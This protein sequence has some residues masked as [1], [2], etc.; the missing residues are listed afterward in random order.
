MDPNGVHI[1]GDV[2]YLAFVSLLTSNNLLDESVELIRHVLEVLPN[3]WRDFDAQ[4]RPS[5]DHT[6]RELETSLR[7]QGKN[8][9]A[10]EVHIQVLKNETFLRPS[11]ALSEDDARA[12]EIIRL[13]Q[14][15]S[16]AGDQPNSSATPSTSQA[17]MPPKAV[18]RSE[19]A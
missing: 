13:L 7:M 2:D 10:D 12:A 3:V 14:D 8:A 18:S 16:I 5:V 6:L 1:M 4:L 17:A 19:T 15:V 11:A 9:E